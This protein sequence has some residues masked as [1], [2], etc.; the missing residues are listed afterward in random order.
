[1]NRR[2]ARRPPGLFRILLPSP[3]RIAMRR[4]RKPAGAGS[5]RLRL[6]RK[7]RNIPPFWRRIDAGL[8]PL[9]TADQQNGVRGIRHVQRLVLAA[10]R[11]P[12]LEG[13]EGRLY[14]P[15]LHE[16]WARAELTAYARENRPLPQL[17]PPHAY[18]NAPWMLIGPV[19]LVAWHGLA[20]RWWPGTDH[21]P[22]AG[23]WKEFGSLDVFRTAHL[24]EW[25]RCLTALTLHSDINH[26]LANVVFG[27]LF[28]VM[29]GRR[30]GAGPAWLLT[31]SAGGLGN[32]CNALYR[33]LSH[34]SLGF[35]TAL[36]GAVGILAALSAVWATGK[37]R[38]LL[39]LAA[40]VGILASIGT[41]DLEGRVDYGA[42]IFG[43]LA[44]ILLGAAY[45][46]LLRLWP[47]P[48]LPTRII[49]GLCAGGLLF[50]AWCRALGLG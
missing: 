7:P 31:V 23:H 44:G 10:R 38:I 47:E 16:R 22:A 28:L 42:H 6:R 48:S 32:M 20:A 9:P 30:I 18:R 12:C 35:S 43:L 19:W 46:K 40:G 15:I 36:F 34:N 24:G 21:L 45:G 3:L 25:W 41:G 49:C 27:S 29:L 14:V 8:L 2:A 5:V 11:I 1:M 26:L 50:A 4:M 39:P 33:P 17:P 37:G 13:G